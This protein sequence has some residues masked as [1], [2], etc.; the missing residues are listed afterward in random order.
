VAESDRQ[1]STSKRL[2]GFRDEGTSLL[3][4]YIWLFWT[5]GKKFTIKQ[6]VSHR[7]TSL[8]IPLDG[9]P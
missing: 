8:E 5:V 3:Y 2:K 6:E 9:D 4:I 7:S 1:G